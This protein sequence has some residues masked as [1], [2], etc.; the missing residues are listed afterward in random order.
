MTRAAC[1]RWRVPDGSRRDGVSE[2]DTGLVIGRKGERAVLAGFLEGMAIHPSALIVEGEA[3][4][5]KTTI[6]RA[7]QTAART[8]GLRVVAARPTSGEMELPYAGLVDL[9]ELV[10]DD[11]L[12]SLAA[13]QRRALERA[14]GR[15]AGESIDAHALARGVLG[16]L[17]GL[18]AGGDLLLVVDDVQWL[19]RPTVAALAFAIRRI[20]ATPLRVLVAVRASNRAATD[21]LGLAGWADV[22]RLVVGPL[23]ATE[24]GAVVRLHLGGQLARPRLEA[25]HRAA[26]G[27]TLFALELA[28]QAGRSDAQTLSA[29]LF[30]RIESLNAPA[31]EAVSCVAASLRP[32]TAML[33]RAGIASDQLV[34]AL[35]AGVL[36]VDGERLRFAHPL[37]AEAAYALLT[38]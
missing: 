18:A 11:A 22:Q 30:A 27:N 4:I 34:S 19:D 32:T 29:A 37:L 13:V 16:L 9:F 20:D 14:L 6:V 8:N 25:L 15:G 28:K 36:Q 5:G 7:A 26:G 3:G 24:L 33:Q 1:G 2:R 31:R 10:S 38:A 35:A 12:A 17:R 21:A 23:S